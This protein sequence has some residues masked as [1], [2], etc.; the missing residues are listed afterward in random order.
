MSGGGPRNL[1]HAGR[2]AALGYDY[3][4]REKEHVRE[5]NLCGSRHHVELSRRDRYDYAA[6]MRLC[7]SC[8]LG[9][10]SPRMTAAE[11]A[12][13]YEKTYRPLVS[14]HHGRLIDAASVQAEQ[15]T[16]AEELIDF[17]DHTLGEAPA[18]V[19]D[20]GGSTGV[21][22]GALTERLGVRATVLDPA[23]EE[24]TVAYGAGMETIEGFAENYNADGRT[25][26]L[27]L[28]CQTVD[29]LL[30]VH[31][32]L[33]AIRAM[34]AGGGHAYVDV[35]DLLFSIRRQRSVEAAVKIDHP[36]YLTRA[37]AMAYFAIVGL[38]VVAERVSEDAHLFGF[39]LSPAKPAE[40]D[41][42]RLRAGADAL[43][44]E[45]SGQRAL[46]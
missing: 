38:E 33:V 23:P 42:P 1:T 4:A 2:I 19:L 6:I 28:M 31:S 27:V 8:G 24:L 20:V 29:H 14:A 46:N 13:F 26:D 41:W 43:L 21:I 39:L 5:C 37:T 45:V 34:V 16:Y 22:A 25:W 12:R 3:V 32:T 36:H 44:D 40:P 10:L 9:F 18:T 11:Y 30:D 7:A 17:L 15:H 35:V